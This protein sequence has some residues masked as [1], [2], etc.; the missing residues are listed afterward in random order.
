MFPGLT[1]PVCSVKKCV[2]TKQALSAHSARYFAAHLSPSTAALS[3][4]KVQALAAWTKY[5][6]T[7]SRCYVVMGASYITWNCEHYAQNVVSVQAPSAPTLGT[8]KNPRRRAFLGALPGISCR[9]A[10]R[11]AQRLS[12]GITIDYTRCEVRISMSHTVFLCRSIFPVFDNCNP[13][14]LKQCLHRKAKCT[15]GCPRGVL[16]SAPQPAPWH[17]GEAVGTPLGAAPSISTARP[18]QTCHYLTNNNL[19]IRPFAVHQGKSAT[20]FHHVDA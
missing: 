12:N 4:A 13:L 14:T 15:V 20:V 19:R 9:R 18:N 2:E 7:T 8:I 5:Y 3:A 11:F 17:L 1:A 10:C 16:P 6:R